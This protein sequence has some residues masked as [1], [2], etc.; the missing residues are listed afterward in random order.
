MKKHNT[1]CINPDLGHLI[2]HYELG[3]L[4]E[5]ERDAFEEHLLRCEF[6]AQ[7][8]ELM[9]DVSEALL[10]NRERIRQGLAEDGI[11]FEV[12]KKKL[13]AAK[14]PEH[15]HV[16][17]RFWEALNMSKHTEQTRIFW[18]AAG[19]AV[20]IALVAVVIYVAVS[21]TGTRG[22]TPYMPMLSFKVLPYEGTLT[23]RGAE[24][25]EGQE[26]FE[27]GMEAYLQ[28]DY[29]KAIKLLRQATAKS[30]DQPTWWLYLGVCHYLLRDAK[31][32]IKTLSRADELAQG[33]VRI[34]SRW[35]LAQAYL[36]NG[37]RDSAEPLL[38]WIVTQ[39][40]DHQDDATNLLTKLRQTGAV[41]EVGTDRPF[42]LYPSGGQVFLAG[43]T[44]PVEWNIQTEQPTKRPCLWLSTDGGLTFAT[45][46]TS[47]LD[48]DQTAWD[49]TNATIIGPH[50]SLRVDVTM[51]NGVVHGT[52][53]KEFAIVAP[54]VLKVQSPATGVNWQLG[55]AH[56]ISWTCAGAWP[57]KYSIELHKVIAPDSTEIVETLT[58]DL[59]GTVSNWE[60][61]DLRSPDN[62]PEAG[63][64]YRIKVVGAFDVGQVDG[65]SD[66]QFALAAPAVLTVD[67]ST[68]GGVAWT[69]GDSVRLA[70]VCSQGSVLRYSIQSCATEYD[71]GTTLIDN[72]PGNATSWVW[73]NCGPPGT[74]LIRVI[75]HFAQGDVL[76]YS[77]SRFAIQ[78]RSDYAG[79]PEMSMVRDSRPSGQESNFALQ[80]NYPNPFNASTNISFDLRAAGQIK[81][82]VYNTLGQKVATLVDGPMSSGHHQVQF[83]GRALA[84]GMYLYRLESNGKVVQK[85]M[86]LT[87]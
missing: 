73:A 68:S 46:L 13:T 25:I 38:E 53:T 70:W 20:G 8:V 55:F 47:E 2:A 23:L 48:D 18:R 75:A 33:P 87:K 26:L 14:T 35:F 49:W 9:R 45:M 61:K 17:R 51:D 32:A 10:A 12:L 54:P 27:Q 86:I 30:A 36:L 85:Q 39:K 42:L 66:G 24:K 56:A 15:P 40:K 81:L 59:P 83:D 64:H 52:V 43:S 19:V 74:H 60:W 29:K 69:E 77:P 37:D 57:P 82:S 34:R 11:T 71:P 76:S 22:T 58:G 67:T 5:S 41:G 84:S 16:F 63:A 6:C 50:L 78:P 1:N 80:Q 65:W 62:A 72:V 79:A 44:I 3:Q 7:E 4:S 28:A 21:N 31:P